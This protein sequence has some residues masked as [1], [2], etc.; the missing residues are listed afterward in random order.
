MSAAEQKCN[1]LPKATLILSPNY[2]LS[3]ALSQ[4][5]ARKK[6]AAKHWNFNFFS[7]FQLN[8]FALNTSGDETNYQQN[9]EFNL[10]NYTAIKHV[11]YYSCCPD[12]PFPD[13]TYF[14]VLRRRPMFYVFNLILPC[15]LI[16]GIGKNRWLEPNIH[17]WKLTKP[18][19]FLW[20]PLLLYLKMMKN[21]RICQ[22]PP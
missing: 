4:P 20:F 19:D 21:K 2:S 7:Y 13:I 18:T 5:K 14:I 1:T 16:N 15:V 22:D 11:V 17:L 3:N 8:V 10:E 12:A 6:I 9:G